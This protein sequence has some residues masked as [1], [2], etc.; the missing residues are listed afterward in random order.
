MKKWLIRLLI[1]ELLI[2]GY[3][4][5]RCAVLGGCTGP[6][7]VPAGESVSVTCLML[8]LKLAFI[9]M[10]PTLIVAFLVHRDRSK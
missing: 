10:G 3:F 1:I 6:L 2:A 8:G 4:V 7:C 5:W 9:L